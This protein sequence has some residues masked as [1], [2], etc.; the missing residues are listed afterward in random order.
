MGSALDGIRVVDLSQ[1][2]GAPYC[3]QLLADMGADV[4]KVESPVAAPGARTGLGPTVTAVDGSPFAP[5]AFWFACNRNK[6]S[7]LLDLKRPEA[8]EVLAGLVARADVVLENYSETTRHALGLDEAWGHAIRP[9]LIWASLTGLGRDG[10]DRAR[11]GW[12]FLAQARGGFLSITGDPQGPPMKSGNSLADYLAGLHLAVGIL[13]ALRHR[14][15]TGEGQRVD[16]ALLDSIVACTDGFPL[17]SSIAGQV[18]QRSGNFHPMRLPGYSLYECKDGFIALGAVGP[19]MTRLLERM[20]RSDLDLDPAESDV[21]LRRERG[22]AT[23]AAISVWLCERTRDEAREELD[24]SRVPNEPVRD[25]AEIWDD[26]QLR[27]RGMFVDYD[28]EPLGRFAAIGSPIHLSSTPVAYR[29]SPPLPGEHTR[30]VLTELLGYDAARLR[31][32]EAAEV[33]GPAAASDA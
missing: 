5:S 16:L 20:G 21:A 1:M 24:A 18:P 9:D 13:G 26:P 31:A 15:R 23:V 25:N 3:S 10:P 27:A 17:W 32:L 8:M 29:R 30:E 14:E 22:D 28:Y 11:D 4:I 12:D 7:V 33:F 2:I 19:S 6:R